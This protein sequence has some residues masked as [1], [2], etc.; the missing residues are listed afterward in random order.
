MPYLS[1]VG[2]ILVPS[3]GVPEAFSQQDSGGRGTEALGLVYFK[4]QDKCE[5]NFR[6]ARSG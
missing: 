2:Y 5:G 6:Q 4:K 3:D 1:G